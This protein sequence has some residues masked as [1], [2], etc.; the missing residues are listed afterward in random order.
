MELV[1]QETGEDQGFIYSSPGGQRF[2]SLHYAQNDKLRNRL[3]ADMK[4]LEMHGQLWPQLEHS[5]AVHVSSRRLHAPWVFWNVMVGTTRS[6]VI[7]IFWSF[8]VFVPMYVL[9]VKLFLQPQLWKLQSHWLHL[10]IWQPQSFP[11]FLGFLN[12]VNIWLYLKSWGQTFSPL[13]T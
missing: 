9:T 4:A 8:P 13:R 7:E 12:C 6:Q 1:E 5:C 11:L 3:A 10:Y 2:T